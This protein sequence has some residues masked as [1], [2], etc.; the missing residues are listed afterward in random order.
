M[1][2]KRVSRERP[3]RSS[4]MPSLVER[5]T[6]N[7]YQWEVRG[8]GWQ[9]W[10]YPV[11]IEP[12]FVPFSHAIS[13]ERR[14]DD[15]RRPSDTPKTLAYASLAGAMLSL[16][17]L[18]GSFHP[19]F[20]F[21]TLC[22][23]LWPSAYFFKGQDN[24]LVLIKDSET[25]EQEEVE[26]PQT[27]EISQEELC[28]MQMLL[29]SEAEIGRV[30]SGQLLLSLKYVRFP[31]SFE[32]IGTHKE[33]VLQ[34]TCHRDDKDQTLSQLQAHFPEGY[35]VA[36]DDAM[37]HALTDVL[38]QESSDAIV[39]DFGLSNEFMQ[40]TN[41]ALDFRNDPLTTFFGALS[42]LEIKEAGFF[43]VIFKPVREDWAGSIK[44]SVIDW[45]GDA[46]FLDAPDIAKKA[47]QKIEH[48]LFAAVIRAGGVASGKDAALDIVRRI[49]AGLE[50]FSLPE[51]NSFIP[52]S[53]DEYDA[54]D[55]VSDVLLR[56]SHRSG[57]LL[58][59]EELVS[60]VHLPSSSVKAENLVRLSKKGKTAPLI[61]VGNALTLGEN[62]HG[63]KRT[64]VGLNPAQ[65][66]RHLYAI[67]ASGTG[68]STLLLNMIIQ[69]IKNGE[70]V[71]VLDPHGD[72]IDRI[73]EFIPEERHRDVV[74]FDPAD[75][76][77]PI[78]FNILSARSELE[79]TLFA[80]D[81]VSVFR[82]FS[83]SWGDQM[84]S[85]LANALLAFLENP[86]GG[87]LRDLRQFLI[88][89]AYR[90]AYLRGV[91]D[92]EVIFY[93][94]REFPLLA[95]RPQA[96]I[97]TRLDT[98]LR[99]RVIRNIVS[100]KENRLN[101]REML[102]HSKIFL[103]KLTQGGIGEEN[104]YLLGSLL[105]SKLHQTVMSRQDTPEEHRKNFFL[106][107]DEFQH[108]TTP[109]MEAMLSG[110][111]KYHLAL[112]LAHQE[113][114]QIWGK[115]R[116]VASSVISNP[117]TRICFRLGD[118]DAQKLQ[119]GFSSFNAKDLQSLGTGEAICRM[120]RAEYDFTLT[121]PQAPQILQ[122]TAKSR[123]ETIVALS[124]SAYAAKR[125]EVEGQ[126]R[127]FTA[128]LAVR[129]GKGPSQAKAERPLYNQKNLR[130]ENKRSE[131]GDVSYDERE[132]LRHISTHPG[133]FVTKIYAALGLSGYK[134]DKIKE[135]LLGKGFVIQEETRH[136]EG[137]RVAKVLV[138][139]A[140]GEQYLS[141]PL[142]GKGG[143]LH[144]EF[145][146]MIREQAELLGWKAKIE[147]RIQESGESVDI[148]LERDEM[149]VAIEISVTTD[150]DN[151]IRNIRKCLVAGYD[152]VICAVSEDATLQALKTKGRRTFSIEER[153]RIR[154]V[155]PTMVKVLLD[156]MAGRTVVSERNGG[157]SSN[158]NQKQML[159]TREAANFLDVSTLTLYSWVSQRKIPHVKVG[160]LTKFKLED[161]V[162]WL[163][164]RRKE[165]TN[166]H[167][168]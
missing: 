15:G 90:E 14:I 96:P 8:R 49:G 62:I 16:I 114:R 113:L 145:Q 29:P 143:D 34:V 9:V 91:T 58:N 130:E 83:T 11:D 162:I 78:G 167:H 13:S 151:E 123:R 39:V 97:L 76:E 141:L 146:L 93:W 41:T 160:R 107:I 28:F 92:P 42:H 72:L 33:I 80:S 163:N 70:G 35:Y 142:S 161:L 19:F 127:E 53:N 152:Y 60:L 148:G 23:S 66:M 50:Q 124:R 36:R 43:Q 136:G 5:L 12:P 27:L 37:R 4:A 140:K 116:D 125:E 132:F 168:L 119:E 51:S 129:A 156:E 108:F 61:A 118:F 102:D 32:I 133:L 55:H 30:S 84:N 7:F 154:Y 120:E 40:P 122:E 77:Y 105:V 24:T 112:I 134:G 117:Y 20:L 1:I 106:Y 38:G 94:E 73:L 126:A 150:A 158:R 100:Q 101:F 144:K 25:E 45:N 59:A 47:V 81:L 71:G 26:L 85:V 88:D 157:N 64:I 135:G 3:E 159:D 46:F 68:K 6:E 87:T 89:K 56:Q 115:D 67:G 75:T 138:L 69:D 52:L 86:Q 79:K 98:F 155:S 103:C 111:R 21:L 54:D 109:S 99:P 74:L 10:P 165:E 153:K 121:C 139:T 17:I 110:A 147:E 166:G 131:I 82:R 2:I 95:G 18:L 65:R 149:T 128:P 63:G 31:V 104:S 44:R 48:P 22:F 137:G 57:M 164:R